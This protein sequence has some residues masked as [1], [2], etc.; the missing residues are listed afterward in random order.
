MARNFTI[1]LENEPGMLADLGEAVGQAGINLAGGCG[2]VDGAEGV[3]HLLVEDGA[4]EARG[5]IEATGLVVRDE[6]EVLV[7]DVQDQPGTLGSYARKLAQAGVNIDLFYVATGTR[8]VF[9]VEDVEQARAAL[10]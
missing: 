4:E 8:L 1:V 6:R 9:G 3:I 2:S 10:D 7:V 5:A